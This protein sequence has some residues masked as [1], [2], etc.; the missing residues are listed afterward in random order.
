MHTMEMKCKY[1][2]KKTPSDAI[3]CP[4]CGRPLEK[5]KKRPDRDLHRKAPSQEDQK[6]KKIEH[7]RVA[8]ILFYASTGILGALGFM[9]IFFIGAGA[10]IGINETYIFISIYHM[11]LAAAFWNRPFNAYQRGNRLDS[12][13][14]IL[15][16]MALLAILIILSISNSYWV[17]LSFDLVAF[18]IMTFLYYR[19]GENSW[20]I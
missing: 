4:Y 10:A 5:K 20:A 13:K 12:R 1:C 16:G 15:Y 18:L 6:L 19:L 14:Y 2:R 11:A 9:G 17:T 8:L 7:D 3:F